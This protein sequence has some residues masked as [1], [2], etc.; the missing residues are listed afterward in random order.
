MCRVSDELEKLRTFYDQYTYDPKNN[1]SDTCETAWD[2]YCNDNTD[3]NFKYGCG[4][5]GDVNS[6]KS[7]LQRK[8]YEDLLSV[9]IG[10]PKK[11]YVT[12]CQ[13]QNFAFWNKEQTGK[14]CN[15]LCLQIKNNVAGKYSEIKDNA[16]MTQHCNKIGMDINPKKEP[17]T[18]PE[19]DNEP[20]PEN[21]NK[22]SHDKNKYIIIISSVCACIILL[23]I[24]IYVHYTRTNYLKK[25]Y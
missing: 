14:F 10:Q 2:K 25:K 4:C 7:N 13:D 19:P 1:P 5:Y 6:I 22:T 20:E 21:K 23:V 8:L 24:I 9:G 15:S 18:E 11:C 17:E 3:T 16:V 12:E